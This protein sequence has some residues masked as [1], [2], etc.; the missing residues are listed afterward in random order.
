MKYIDKTFGRVI[1]VGYNSIYPRDFTASNNTRYCSLFC[2]EQINWSFY[3]MLLYQDEHK[4]EKCKKHF[5]MDIKFML[6]FVKGP[7]MLGNEMS[8]GD[9][10]MAPYFERMCVLREF[11]GFEVPN[12][13]E[14]A[15]W[16]VWYSSVSNH[17][18]VY[19][20]Q[21]MEEELCRYYEPYANGTVRNEDYYTYYMN[22]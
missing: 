9:L 15:K 7:F 20:T 22:D 4:Q 14:F 5:L 3:T 18:A 10:M 13:E 11:R 2:R 8:I 16:H 12:L 6:D 1:P 21:K 17:P 19:Q